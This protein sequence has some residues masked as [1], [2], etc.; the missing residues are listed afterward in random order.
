MKE[1]VVQVRWGLMALTLFAGSGAAG[2][3]DAKADLIEIGARFVEVHSRSEHKAGDADAQF[4]EDVITPSVRD[5]VEAGGSQITDAQRDA[6]IRFLWASRASAS[7]AISEIAA[8]LYGAERTK[9][10]AAVA[11]VSPAARRVVLERIKS[12]LALT[13]RP[14]PRPVCNGMPE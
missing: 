2:E 1:A 5:V 13:G 7:E 9:L 3:R 14:V 6:A 11:K 10:C 8:E 4:I 12:G